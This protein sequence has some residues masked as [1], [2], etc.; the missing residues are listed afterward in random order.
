[1]KTSFWTYFTSGYGTL[2]LVLLGLGLVTQSHIDAGLFGLIGFP[3]IA[4]I[5]AW[6]RRSKDAEVTGSEAAFLPPRMTE[7]LEAH[8]EFLNAPQR[9]RDTAFHNWLNNPN[10]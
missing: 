8:P 2:W 7:F 6:I 1:M 9:L 10:I 4:A 3:I 5:Y